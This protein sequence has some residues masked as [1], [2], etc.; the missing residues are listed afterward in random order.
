MT[1][2]A[3]TLLATAIGTAALS[4]SAASAFADYVACSGNTC[5]HVKERYTYPKESSVVIHEADTWKPAPGIT[6]REHEGR[7]YWRSGVWVDF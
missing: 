7:G 3:K 2:T 4:L 1:R 6:V 5:W